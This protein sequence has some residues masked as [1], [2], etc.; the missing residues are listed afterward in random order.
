LNFLQYLRYRKAFTQQELAKRINRSKAYISR[1][2]LGKRIPVFVDADLIALHLG[3]PVE[4]VFPQYIRR[5][6]LPNWKEMMYLRSEGFDMDC[7]EQVVN[8]LERVGEHPERPARE[9]L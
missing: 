5:S 8:S 1:V 7:Y 6:R 9:Q 4:L 3:V 2:E